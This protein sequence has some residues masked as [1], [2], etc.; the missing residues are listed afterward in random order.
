MKA[1]SFPASLSSI[2]GPTDIRIEWVVESGEPKEVI[3]RAATAQSADLVVLGQGGRGHPRPGLFHVGSVV[4]QLAHTLDLPIAVIPP[5][6]PTDHDHIVIGVDETAESKA[7]IHWVASTA[8]ALSARVT[9]IHVEPKWILPRDDHTDDDLRWQTAMWADPVAR[10]GV[11]TEPVVL[12]ANAAATPLVDEARA[13]SASMLVI[14]A[15][16]RSELIG[17]RAGGVEFEVLHHADDLVVV[18][19][20]GRAS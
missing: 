1:K 9:A 13:R 16:P 2:T 10:A 3:T 5:V 15:R 17:A 20:P 11:D 18:M 7:A 19:V 12:W 8:P 14:G 6:P 4:E